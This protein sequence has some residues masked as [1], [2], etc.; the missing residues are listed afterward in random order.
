MLEFVFATEINNVLLDCDAN[1][2]TYIVSTAKQCTPAVVPT[3]S[4]SNQ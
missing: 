1:Q 3:D 4:N 2:L